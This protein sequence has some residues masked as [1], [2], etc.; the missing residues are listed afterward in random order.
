M[1]IKKLTL[2]DLERRVVIVGLLSL[3]AKKFSLNIYEVN[4]AI[5]I[6]ISTYEGGK[7]AATAYNVGKKTVI[8]IS[9]NKSQTIH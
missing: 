4:A 1:Q 8:M 3:F 7:S 6:A 2:E 5:R 9:K